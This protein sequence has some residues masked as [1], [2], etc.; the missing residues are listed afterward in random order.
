MNWTFRP[1]KAPGHQQLP[2]IASK[3][4]VLWPLWGRHK[5]QLNKTRRPVALRQALHQYTCVCGG[6]QTGLYFTTLWFHNQTIH[7]S[8]RQDQRHPSTS[9]EKCFGVELCQGWCL[10]SFSALDIRKLF[11]ITMAH[12]T[13]FLCFSKTCRLTLPLLQHCDLSVFSHDYMIKQNKSF[14]CFYKLIKKKIFK[15]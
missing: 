1:S 3:L 4:P 14:F 12:E 11:F 9:G 8:G 6:W 7:R 10:W 5:L 15:C 2:R 13:F